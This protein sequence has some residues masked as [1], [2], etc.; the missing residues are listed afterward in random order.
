VVAGDFNAHSKV[1]DCHPQQGDPRR[2]DAVISW[3]TGL[4]LLL[5]NRGSTN[6]CVLLRGESIIDLTWASP[7]AARIFREWAVVT[8]G[9]NLSDHRY[10]VWALGR[11][12]P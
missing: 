8:E 12:V 10:I 1:W 11:Q 9:E 4:G 7:S 2:G 3:A 6:T 5:M